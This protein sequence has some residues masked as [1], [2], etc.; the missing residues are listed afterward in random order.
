MPLTPVDER[1]QMVLT[2]TAIPFAP[3]AMLPSPPQEVEKDRVLLVEDN[4]VR[5]YAWSIHRPTKA[6]VRAQV[7]QHLGKRL[8][9]KMG[10]AVVTA[11]NGKE[12]V[13]L[14]A[15]TKFFCIFMDCQMPGMFPSPLYSISLTHGI[16]SLG[17]FRGNVED[18]RARKER[19][20]QWTVTHCRAHCQRQQ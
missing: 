9:E 20:N 16:G 18:T 3:A 8:L 5:G 19:H 10:Y 7:N 17:W 1:K 15:Q 2:E 6:H 12:A 4:L 11:N 13:D 14:V